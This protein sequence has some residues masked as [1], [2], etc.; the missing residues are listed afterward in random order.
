MKNMSKVI[1]F[2]ERLRAVHLVRAAPKVVAEVAEPRANEALRAKAFEEGRKEAMASFGEQ[3]KAA[4]E[5]KGKLF[6]QLQLAEKQLSDAAENALPELIVEGARR[7]IS[8]WTPSPED[9]Q[10]IVGEM[11]AGIAGDRGALQIRLNES[12]KSHLDALEA[13][14]MH[15]FGEITL[16]EDRNLKPGECVVSGRFGLIDGRFE[17]KL[18]GLRKL[19]N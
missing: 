2:Q 6:K 9:V 17:T 1:K 12:D 18:E 14:D 4:Q 10:R 7:V 19:F 3:I 8:G 11:L 15:E 16:I 5:L 13:N